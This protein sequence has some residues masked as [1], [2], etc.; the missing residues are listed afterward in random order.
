MDEQKYRLIRDIVESESFF[1]TG[2]DRVDFEF[3]DFWIK[4]ISRD[5]VFAAYL[6]YFCYEKKLPLN[7]IINHLEKA[8]II[9]ALLDS[10][11]HQKR[12][13]LALGM[14][15]VTLNRKLKKYGIEPSSLKKLKS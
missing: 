4:R 15:Y 12:A 3:L 14:D 5:D 7:N 11:G 8:I 6:E 1:L 2:L 10:R 9:W 13:A